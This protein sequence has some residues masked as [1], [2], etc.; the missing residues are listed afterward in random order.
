MKTEMILEREKIGQML[1]K[2]GVIDKDQLKEALLYKTNKNVYLGK[3]L[4]SLKMATSDQIIQTV[5]EQLKIPWV[6]P[7][8]YKISKDTLKLIK[9]E[10]CRELNVIPLFHFDDQLTIA[11]SDQNNIYVVDELAEETVM[12]INIVLA[13]YQNIR[14]SIG[15]HYNI[16]YQR[17]LRNGTG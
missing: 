11:C 6:N 15:L 10:S 7:L 16:D 9:E 5:S 1:L 12:G 17:N 13:T 2:E 3:A 4:E 8:N 14:K